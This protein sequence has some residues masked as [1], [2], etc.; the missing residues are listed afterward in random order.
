MGEYAIYNHQRIKIG[1]DRNLHVLRFEDRFRVRALPGNVDPVRDAHDC[2]FR[3]PLPEEDHERPGEYS[4]KG[5]QHLWTHDA[6]GFT[7]HYSPESLEPTGYVQARTEHGLLLGIK[8]YHGTR[9]P[10][11]GG[12]VVRIN[13][14]GRAPHLVL[15]SIRCR[16]HESNNRTLTLSPIITCLA[17]R[18]TWS[19][20]WDELL[21]YVHGL[22][23]ERLIGY[24]EWDG[25]G[26][27]PL[28]MTPS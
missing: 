18:E 6:K 8:C 1:T 17:C 7:Q 10:E 23:K 27:G 25:V 20:T 5:Y 19:M 26:V 16:R 4:G 13:W 3:L 9:L 12:D 21:P 28:S 2:Q 14:N 11:P 22:L 24:A 15:R